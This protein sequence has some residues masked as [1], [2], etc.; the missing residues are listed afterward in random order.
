MP[1]IDEIDMKHPYFRYRRMTR[2]LRDNRK[3]ARRLMRM[4]GLEAVYPKPNLSK[5]LH[6]TYTCPLPASRPHDRTPEPRLGNR[7]H[8]FADGQGFYSQERLIVEMYWRK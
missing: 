4:M 7:H 5:R 8:V 2:F 3:H 1:P 6:A